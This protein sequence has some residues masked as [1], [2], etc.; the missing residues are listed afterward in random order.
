MKLG[1][2][3]E[4]IS[5]VIKEFWGKRVFLNKTPLWE[6]EKITW[7]LEWRNSTIKMGRRV[8]KYISVYEDPV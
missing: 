1:L 3:Q 6:V 4:E 7:K 5:A 8:P 2:K